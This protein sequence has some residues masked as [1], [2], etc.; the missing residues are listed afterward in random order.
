MPVQVP[1]PPNPF[2]E[3]LGY[4]DAKAEKRA[5]FLYLHPFDARCTTCPCAWKKLPLTG[6]AVSQVSQS[7]TMA[8]SPWDNLKITRGPEKAI[9]GDP[10]TYS[11]TQDQRNPFWFA[12]LGARTRMRGGKEQPAGRP[13]AASSA[14][15][16]FVGPCS[17]MRLQG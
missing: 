1:E 10:R 2:P 11:Y 3:W 15:M 5:G 17:G 9:D 12:R 6:K 13:E 8:P 16:Y 7:S 14:S 4:Q